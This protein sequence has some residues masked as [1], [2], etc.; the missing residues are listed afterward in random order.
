[1]AR[2][3]TIKPEL[4][5]SESL[6]LVSRDARLCFI[7]MLTQAD[8]EGRLR[9]NQK[10]LASILFPYDD[11]A[12]GLIDGW[13]AELEREGCIRRYNIDG[14][15]FIDFPK[16]H[17]HQKINRP[18][19]S[20]L[21]G[22]S[23]AS[24]NAHDRKGRDQGRERK[25]SRKSLSRDSSAD[26]DLPAAKNPDSRPDLAAAAEI[27]NSTC[28]DLCPRITKIGQFG[29]GARATQL[30][31]RLRDECRGDLELWRAFAERVRASRFLTGQSKPRNGQDRPF[32]ATIDWC[33]QPRNFAKVIEGN[34][35]DGPSL[36]RENVSEWAARL[37]REHAQRHGYH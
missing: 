24:L 28:G 8:D 11:D 29:K 30:A 18:S 13:L 31:A 27:W 4:C 34:Y 23:E 32:M 20:K 35:D 17:D 19:A 7:L 15:H 14:F 33:I 1:M 9:A 6:G 36:L 25:G 3:R 12:R 22:F 2:I 16:W 37:A 5:Q 26:A 10:M 21:P